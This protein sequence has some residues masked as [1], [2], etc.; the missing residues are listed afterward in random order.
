MSATL[1]VIVPVYNEL[2]NL[3]PFYERAQTV[4]DSLAGVTWQLVF[5]N[6]GST[7]GSLERIC[8]LRARD[9][10]VKIIS[11]ARNDH[12]KPATPKSCA[13]FAPRADNLEVIAVATARKSSRNCACLAEN[14]PSRVTS[15]HPC[16][17]P[18]NGC[19]RCSI[20]G[21]AIPAIHPIARNDN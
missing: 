6:D 21:T 9:D 4:L 15:R 3:A 13:H 5:V 11:L 14:A 17:A 8:E 16:N 19:T 2:G 7:D 20:H 1:A 12:P 10:R 18:T